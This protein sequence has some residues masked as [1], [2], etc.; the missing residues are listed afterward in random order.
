MTKKKKKKRSGEIRLYKSYDKKTYILGAGI[1][2][3]AG[4]PVA[5]FRSLSRARA[6]GATLA[7]EKGIKFSPKV[8]VMR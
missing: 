5:R 3:K 2:G 7:K 4:Y 6:I 1:P 8:R